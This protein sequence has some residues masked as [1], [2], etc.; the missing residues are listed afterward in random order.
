MTGTPFAR[1]SR[2]GK[3]RRLRPLALAALDRYDIDVRRITPLSDHLNLLYRVETTDGARYALRISHPTWRDDIELSSELEWLAAL[4]RATDIGAPAPIPNRGGQFVSVVVVDGVPEP[5]R[6]VLFS[7]VAGVKLAGRLTERNV[8]R[9]G[10]LSARLHAH[11]R[12]FTPSA[13]FTTR[14]LDR[15]FPRDE[16]VV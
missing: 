2:L 4:A 15:L 6:A 11:A 9:M 8:E 14:R 7:W 5:R 1:L 16:D 13:G 12:A 10:V 3:L